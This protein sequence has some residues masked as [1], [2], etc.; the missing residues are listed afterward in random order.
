MKRSL[1]AYMKTNGFGNVTEVLRRQDDSQAA[2]L[3]EWLSL[4]P[5]EGINLYS[6]P[7]D[8]ILQMLANSSDLHSQFSLWRFGILLGLSFEQLESCTR[9]FQKVREL[10]KQGNI[11]M[12]LFCWA[13]KD[14]AKVSDLHS[15]LKT[16]GKAEAFRYEFMQV[17]MLN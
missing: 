17:C 11:C 10:E 7:D 14:T 15:A 5:F 4:A 1:E 3:P 8:D 16:L 9:C 13:S 2:P 6:K 12:M